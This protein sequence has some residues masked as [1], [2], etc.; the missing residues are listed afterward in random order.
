MR[1]ERQTRGNPLRTE[2]I[3]HSG[4]LVARELRTNSKIIRIRD[5]GIPQ[6]IAQRIS[7]IASLVLCRSVEEAVVVHFF[8]GVGLV[9]IDIVAF[10]LV[11]GVLDRVYSSCERLL[12]YA[13][14]VAQ[15]PAEKTTCSVEV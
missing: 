7:V 6:R 1:L 2:A 12:C 14:G 11:D 9:D 13:D 4:I 3:I 15:T 8:A 10:E 5:T